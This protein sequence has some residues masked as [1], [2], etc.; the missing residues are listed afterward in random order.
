MIRVNELY[1]GR[2]SNEKPIHPGDYAEDDPRLYGIADYLVANGF[3]V[4]L[5]ESEQSS[6][7]VTEQPLPTFRLEADG[8]M[9]EVNPSYSVEEDTPDDSDPAPQKPTPRKKRK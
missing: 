9:S 7:A 4:R 5:G 2:P 1:Q 3:A 8:S 6:V